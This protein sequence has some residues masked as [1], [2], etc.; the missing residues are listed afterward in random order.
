MP[1]YRHACFS[2][3]C[4][5]LLLLLLQSGQ[6][7]DWE[8]GHPGISGERRWIDEASVRLNEWLFL[9]KY[10]DEKKRI[11]PRVFPDGFVVNKI[12]CNGKLKIR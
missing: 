12:F 10:A 6:V 8:E 4:I 5:G 3:D 11:H 1:V 7:V 9:M 2:S